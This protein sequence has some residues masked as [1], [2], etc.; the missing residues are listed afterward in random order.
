[1][2]PRVSRTNRTTPSAPRF[3][4][5]TS[6][7]TDVSWALDLIGRQFPA[8]TGGRTV[9]F[10]PGTYL[11][12]PYPKLNETVYSLPAHIT[13]SLAD[14]ARLRGSGI[15]RVLVGGGGHDRLPATLSRRAACSPVLPQ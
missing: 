8:T 6:P 4:P 9:L 2:A 11:I 15:T 7:I 12:Y 10:P 13:L 5:A 3:T 1:M 14:G